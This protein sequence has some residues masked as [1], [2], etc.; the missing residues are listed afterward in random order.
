M[1]KRML[2]RG[3]AQAVLAGLLGR[4]LAFA[5]ATTRWSLHGAEHVAPHIAGQPAVFAF[6]HERLPLMP[7]L[8]MLARRRGDRRTLR[9]RVLVSRHADGRFIGALIRS[10]GVD[11]VHGS[12][13]RGG[14]SGLR[15]MLVSLQAGSHVVITPDGPRGPRRQAAPGVANL[16]ALSGAPVLPCS[17]QTSRR[18]VLR[19][20]DR[21][22]IPLPLGRGVI[23]CQP[24]IFVARGAAEAALGAIAAALSEA[25]DTADRL[26]IA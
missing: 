2:R 4:Y 5:L 13:S 10:F 3:P 25:A 19:S 1:L 11:L 9:A 26:A 15:A 18:R 21:M 8:W 24:P 16:A 7:A 20:W 22:V 12:T 6:W 17:A 23:V 14:A